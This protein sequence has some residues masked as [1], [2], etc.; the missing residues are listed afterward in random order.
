M[1]F[2]GNLF[3]QLRTFSPFFFKYPDASVAGDSGISSMSTE[4]ATSYQKVVASFL[5]SVTGKEKRQ[6]S[7]ERSK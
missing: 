5:N 2:P 6:Q 1:S 3:F 7:L 4:D